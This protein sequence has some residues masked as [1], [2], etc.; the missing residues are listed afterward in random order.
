M[1]SNDK[2]QIQQ[3]LT[4]YVGAILKTYETK[5]QSGRA[6][7]QDVA[8]TLIEE[9]MKL[10]A[11]ENNVY[12]IYVLKPL[13]RAVMLLLSQRAAELQ[14]LNTHEA[15]LIAHQYIAIVE[16]LKKVVEKVK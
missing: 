1:Y 8:A 12:D 10:A 3:G 15:S 11:D 6:A 4:S 13:L 2:I 7:K 9:A 5:N 14:K 16:E